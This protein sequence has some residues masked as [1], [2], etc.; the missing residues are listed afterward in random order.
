MAD[1]YPLSPPRAPNEALGWRTSP[2]RLVVCTPRWLAERA[3]PGRYAWGR[4]LLIVSRWDA[5]V[6]LAAVRELCALAPGPAWAETA[7]FL[8]RFGM[9]EYEA[10]R[11]P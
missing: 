11:T 10:F 1:G 3:A 8:S 2:T 9:W 5:E 4:H 7:A 6:A